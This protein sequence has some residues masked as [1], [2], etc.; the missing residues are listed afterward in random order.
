MTACRCTHHNRI[1]F[2][3][4]TADEDTLQEND[5]VTTDTRRLQ[6]VQRKT[7]PGCSDP[8]DLAH[9]VGPCAEQSEINRMAE[10]TERG[11]VISDQRVW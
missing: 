1:P 3:E 2:E 10:R 11:G 8:V 6:D 5:G 4:Y 7:P 9:L